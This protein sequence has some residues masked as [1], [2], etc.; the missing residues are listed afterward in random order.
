MNEFKE[1]SNNQILSEIQQM[2]IDYETIKQRMLK[3]YDELVK[4]ET[5]FQKANEEL[6]KRLNSNK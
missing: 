2:M 6:I 5:R 3:D 1:M 4:I